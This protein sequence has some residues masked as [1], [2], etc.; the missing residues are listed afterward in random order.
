VDD[1]DLFLRLCGVGPF[2]FLPQVLLEYNTG[3]EGQQTRDLFRGQRCHWQ[4]IR[5]YARGRADG[6]ML[7][8]RWIERYSAGF[9]ELGW[10][11]LRRGDYATARTLYTRAA[12]LRP[13]LMLDWNF[14]LDLLSAWKNGRRGA[15][16][17]AGATS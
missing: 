3:S 5:D 14:A 10:Q 15:S 2:G 8:A 11:A 13:R 6:R 9:R 17:A 4:L 12:R 7:R 16:P 1:L